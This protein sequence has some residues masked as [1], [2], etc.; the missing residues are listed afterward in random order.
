EEE[1][2]EGPAPAQPPANAAGPAREVPAEALRSIE[3]LVDDLAKRD[4]FSGVVLLADQGKPVFHKA[5]G[6]ASKEFNVPNNLDTR[7]NLGSINKIF[8]QVLIGQLAA[9]GNL[10]LDDRLGKY[11]PDYPDREAGEKV[12]IRQLLNMTSGI[13]DVFCTE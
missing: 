2:R 6:L 9:A 13:G 10:S 4:E 5:V 11:L 7:F 12:T 1:K 3:T 8:T